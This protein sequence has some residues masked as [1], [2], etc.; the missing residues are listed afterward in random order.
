M[1]ETLAKLGKIGLIPVIKLDSPAEAL[2]LGKALV[3]GGL[4]VAEVTFRTEAAEESIRILANELPELVLGAGTVLTTTQAEAAAAAGARYVVTPGFNPRVVAHCLEMGLPVTPGVNSA[5]QIE[6]AIEMGLD[7]AKF[8]PAGPSGGTEMLKAFAGP[9]GGKISFIPTGGVGPKNLTEYLA[10]PNVF[11]VGGSWMVPSDAVK[12][13]DFARIE[14]LCREARMLSLGFSLLHIGVNPEAGCD[15][16]AE[17]KLLSSMLGMQLKEGANSD[18]VGNS[19]E[20]MKSAGRGAK[21]HIAVG[22]LSVER[23]LE[24]FAGFG[25]KPA[26]ET[27]KTKGNHI[28]VA[29]LDNEICGFAVHFVRK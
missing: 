3:A 5:S 16:A 8:F 7:V 26:A 14:K 23:A 9:Y 18:F 13:G 27:I 29:Y 17:A 12:A 20:F 6:E 11:A 15:S 19:F 10:C 2:P 1:N 28:S 24:W 25:M 4:P 21:G 22:T